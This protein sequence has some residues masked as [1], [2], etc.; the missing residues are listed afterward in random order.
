M[1][2]FATV[3]GDPEKYA[4]YAQHSLS[5]F[6]EPESVIV[7]IDDQQSMFAAYNEV[8]DA[9]G[10]MEN[11][12]AL[13][14]LHEDVTFRNPKLCDR[15]REAL[16]QHPDVA[17][18]GV[19]GATETTGIG[20]W[21]GKIFGRVQ[22][23]RATV[24]GERGFNEVEIVDGLCMILSPW[25]IKNLR[26][27]PDAYQPCFHGYDAELCFLARAHGKKV[28]TIDLD[29]FHYTKGGYGN[30]PLWRQ[31]NQTFVRRWLTS[32]AEHLPA[33]WLQPTSS[34]LVCGEVL[35]QVA[36][37]AW[38]SVISCPSCTLG[39]TW[40]P[41]SRA[42]ESDHV[43]DGPYL[44]RRMQ[45][46][47]Q[48]LQEARIRLDW[49]GTHASRGASLIDVGSATGELLEA[50]KEVGYKVFGVEPSVSAAQ[51]SVDAGISET[52][53]GTLGE[54]LQ[55]APAERFDVATLFHVLEH[56]DEPLELL[57][58]IGSVLETNGLLFVEVPNFASE[59]ARRDPYHWVGADHSQLNEHVSHYTP[60]ALT[61]ALERTGFD[62]VAVS[63]VD[64]SV[65]TPPTSVG[66]L[67]KQA[68][69]LGFDE[70]P[71]DLLRV[72]ARKR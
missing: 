37:V 4:T 43:W 28:A 1:I 31:I 29:V 2:A 55:S 65:Y 52:F 40:P 70:L 56:V 44:G 38:R 68:K 16:S 14:L 12:E 34:C 67:Y 22:E 24:A 72:V 39:H 63:E 62:V 47:S 45:R 61:E 71:R 19:V 21:D 3:V 41:P 6:A 11:I 36:E 46:R 48:W 26:Y 66:S 20:W 15:I 53:N 64:Y 60:Q 23:T 57:G 59:S 5:L 35:P 7:T 69:E 8:L 17:V 27:N 32:A 58:E 33:E 25:A 13:V 50:G 18:F 49:I 42:I 30:E 51:A 10:E 54:W 9:I